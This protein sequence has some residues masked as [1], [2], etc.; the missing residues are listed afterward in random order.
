[1]KV[2]REIAVAAAPDKVWDFLWNTDRVARCLPGCRDVRTLVPHERY[3]A[4]VAEQV[5]P[6]TVRFPL[7]IRVVEAEEPRRLRAEAIG[8][9]EAMGTSLRV[10][11][12]LRLE[13]AGSGSRLR[14][15]SDT[16]VS[17]PL[18]TLAHGMMEQ[19]AHGIMTKFAEAVQRELEGAD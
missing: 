16:N 11:L 8:R 19:R 4:V 15:V 3:E 2:E 9:D 1:V 18:A 5:G 17:G 13:G 12:D 7:D 14:I 6:F 10:T